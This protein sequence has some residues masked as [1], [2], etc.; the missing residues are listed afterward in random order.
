MTDKDFE[1]SIARI[2]EIKRELAP[3]EAQ[4]KP[5][6]DEL[7]AVKFAIMA[8]MQ[9]TRSKRTEAVNGFYVVRA[10]RKNVNIADE[11]LVTSW[12]L[13]QGF[14]LSEYT[15]LDTTRVKSAAESAMKENG[16]IVPGVEVSSTEYLTI[17]EAK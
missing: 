9:A 15:K 17:K 12:L 4:M 6:L 8:H 13:D 7:E 10:E 14:D 2:A 1:G 5:L 11:E 16:E 3:L